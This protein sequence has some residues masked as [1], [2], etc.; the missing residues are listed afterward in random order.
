[1]A[2][3]VR[4][5]LDEIDTV[6]EIKL[7]LAHDKKCVCVVVEGEDDQR[8]FGPLLEKNVELLQSYASKNGV[9]EIIKKYFPKNKRVIGIRDKDY[10]TKPVSRRIFHCDYCCAEMM[11]VA[12]DDCFKRVYFNFYRGK[13]YNFVEL[14]LHCLERLETLSKLRKL[15]EV[16]LW[17]VKFDMIKP[18]SLYDD[19]K[20]QMNSNI[21]TVLNGCNQAN[22]IDGTRIALCAKLRPCITIDDYLNI[23]NGHDFI[24][25]LLHMCN[26]R[27]CSIKSIESS[28]RS[29]FGIAEFRQ[30]ILY[31]SLYNYQSTANLD[32]VA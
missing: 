20:R 22:P 12:I 17:R 23:T 9:D 13:Q 11:I 10:Q 1:M 21:I 32:I 14:R 19:D 30:T 24:N 26:N 31:K 25:L 29:T 8:L 27:N 4:D 5:K 15:N 28:L 7:L 16:A 6:S 18:G 3:S 2:N